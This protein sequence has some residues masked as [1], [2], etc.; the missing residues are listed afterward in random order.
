M[1]SELRDWSDVR[2]FLAVVRAGSTLAAS[3]VLGMAQPT[4][5]RRIEA[6]EHALGLVL[7][8]RDTRGFQPTPAARALITHAQS[9]EAAAIGFSEAARQQSAG[10]SRTIRF[11]AFQEAFNHRLGSVIEA[12]ARTHPEVRFEFLPSNHRLDLVGGEADVA[13]RGADVV[14]ETTLICRTVRQIG[15]SLFAS[16]SYAERHPLPSS[17]AEFG[18][19][20]F[21][22]HQG[23]HVDSRS[24]QWVLSRID[25][26]QIE[27]AVN[28]MT[29]M[30]AAIQMGAGIGILPTP[31]A[32]NNDTLVKCFELPPETATTIWLL[33]NPVAWR[34]PEVKAFAAFF[35]PHY[36]AQF[37]ASPRLAKTD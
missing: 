22:V 4:V 6:L 14:R 36:R 5:A 31:S 20:K 32:N 15:F 35:V 33:V 23:R 17:D 19:H 37:P 1:K 13:L 21:A 9:F 29:A 10:T 18:G 12:F 25:P 30:E 27:M 8:E 26:G 3:K 24:N 11:T 7:F 28:D 34:R 2:V 16:K